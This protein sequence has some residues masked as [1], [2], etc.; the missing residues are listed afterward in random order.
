LRPLCGFVYATFGAGVVASQ[1]PITC[2]K[3]QLSRTLGASY[4][5]ENLYKIIYNK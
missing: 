2:P 5:R 4:L 1:R 3:R